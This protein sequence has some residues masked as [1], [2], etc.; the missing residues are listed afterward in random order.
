[1]TKH[2]EVKKWVRLKKRWE[3]VTY[4]ALLQYAKEYEMTVKDFN[5]HKSNGGI[6]QPMTIDVIKTFKCGKK[7]NRNSSSNRMS[8][9]SNKDSKTCSKCNMRHS[10]KGCPE[11][12]KKCHKYGFKIILVLAAGQ[13]RM[14][15]LA[16]DAREVEHQLVAGLQRDVTDPVEADA[17]DQGHNQEVDHQH[18]TPTASKLTGMI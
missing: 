14:W 5:H 7:G 3:D 17:P 10:C 13:L 12:G 18:E 11:F 6:A 1:M 4:S 15:V 9:S 2:F 8:S 16:K